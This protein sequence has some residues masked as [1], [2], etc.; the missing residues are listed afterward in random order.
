MGSSKRQR[1]QK[2]RGSLRHKP[3]SAAQN[4]ALDIL[5]VTPE[6]VIAEG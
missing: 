3:Q 1:K 2:D 6:D 5:Q 4:D